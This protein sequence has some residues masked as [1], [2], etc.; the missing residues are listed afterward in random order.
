M[1]NAVEKFLS[2]LMP[3]F[4]LGVTLAVTLG[5]FFVFSY[6]IFWGLLFGG[7]LWL[8][9]TIRQFFVAKPPQEKKREGRIIEHDN[10]K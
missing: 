9:S 6:V 4:I 3:F 1:S 10:R 8:L 2:K 7:V 5:L